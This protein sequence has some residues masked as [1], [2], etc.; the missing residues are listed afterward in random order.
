MRDN[1]D[2]HGAIRLLVEK[3]K[4]E[5]RT[6]IVPMPAGGGKGARIL[7]VLN[8]PGEKGAQESGVLS[9]WLN[10]DQTANKTRLWL[11]EVGFTEDDGLV[12]FWNAFNWAIPKRD[13]DNPI[14]QR[15]GARH[16]SRLVEIL[17][18]ELRLV[19]PMGAYAKKVLSDVEGLPDSMRHEGTDQPSRA[20]KAPTI[21]A[22]RE[23]F[24]VAT[25]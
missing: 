3:M 10:R 15:R 8:D 4:D 18:P 19:V 14:N 17:R 7:L 5:C 2:R 6:A 24:R 11:E 12:E 23:A 1:A 21:D 13:R 22:L 25:E 16:L 20:K 9:C